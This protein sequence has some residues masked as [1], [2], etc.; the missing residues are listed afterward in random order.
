MPLI[1]FLCVR[2]FQQLAQANS[3]RSVSTLE[4]NAQ[5]ALASL[6]KGLAQLQQAH[7]AASKQLSR[8]DVSLKDS[9]SNL[10]MY[11]QVSAFCDPICFSMWDTETSN[12]SANHKT[13]NQQFLGRVW[14]KCSRLWVKQALCSLHCR[15]VGGILSCGLLGVSIYIGASNKSHDSWSQRLSLHSYLYIGMANLFS[16]GC[17]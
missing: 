6:T 2:W 8:V 17:V 1:S 10:T 5:E 11:Q 12:S 16:K 7:D 13:W 9:M 4:T 15:I 14:F 3:S